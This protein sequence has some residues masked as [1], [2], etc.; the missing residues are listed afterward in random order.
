MPTCSQGCAVRLRSTLLQVSVMLIA[1]NAGRGLPAGDVAPAPEYAAI[2]LSVSEFLQ[3]EIA[4]RRIPALSIALVDGDRIVWSAGF[5]V[6]DASTGR[7]ANADTV[8]RVGSLSKLL[9]D[10]AVMQ[11]IE[12][13]KIDL[14]QD[15]RP[16]L[17][18]FA[19]RYRDDETI[20]LRRLM[21]H[22]SGLVRE[23]PVGSYFDPDDPGLAATIASLN[24]TGPVYPVGTRTKYS[25]AGIAV[26]GAVVEAVAG[27]PFEDA[28]QDALLRPLGMSSSTF[29]R[30]AAPEDRLAAGWMWSHDG[31][32]FPAPTFDLGT[33]PAG[34][35]YASVNDFGGFLAA[36]FRGGEGPQGRV[37]R[38]ETLTA[39]LTA[40]GTQPGDFGLG[41]ALS[42]FEGCRAF[43]HGGAV[44][45]F[46]TQ[47]KGLPDQKLGV[48]ATAS[49]DGANGFVSHVVDGTLSM[50]LARQRGA[51]P[52][53]LARTVDVPA[54]RARALAGRY[55]HG[56]DW[57]ELEAREGRLYLREGA[58]LSEVRG[59]YGR[60]MVDDVYAWG[61]EVEVPADDRIR[62][63][64]RTFTRV[65]TPRPAP[66]PA[67]FRGLIGEYGWDHN[68]LYIY[69]DRGQLYCL[70]EWFYFYPL[71][72]LSENEFAFP[73]AGLYHGEKLIFQRDGQGR[74]ESVEA[75][76]VVFQRREATDAAETYRITPQKLIDEL[77]PIAESATPP[78]ESG[79]F[80]PS[81]LVELTSLEPGIRLDIRYASENNFLGTVFYR[82]PR[83]FLQ[84][85]AAEAVARAH[86]RAAEHGLG[87]LVY[88]GY[89]PWSVTRMFHDAMPADLR[90]FVADPSQGSRHNRGCAVDLTLCDLATG[91]PVEMVSGYDE[92]T[93]RA[94]PNYPGGTSLGRWN[95]ALLRSL[96]E[97]QGF[98]V[99]EYEW[100]HFDFRDWRRYPIGNLPFEKLG[101]D[102]PSP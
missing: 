75:A 80:L 64:N 5:G 66:A 34:N 62:F 43:G 78:T 27:K 24:T 82:Q 90:R 46:A 13:E 2:A 97:E 33:L 6:A 52:P 53:P 95:R 91:E 101:G 54:E 40:Q 63:R 45:G 12:A 1:L 81:D 98:D 20:S 35:L 59:A 7:A 79:D 21:S 77:R 93:T 89:R 18:G 83:A 28:L 57:L 39:M 29:L 42:E 41:F 56:D 8:Y 69:E 61:P 25:N 44:Y 65:A 19:P 36:M 10:M 38:P 102:A 50:M 32:R 86:R 73:D 70:I 58:R 15:V 17:P 72:E 96:M 67:R 49:L 26:V 30:S 48:I 4:E 23:S 68:V 14:E 3:A 37:L 76:S 51:A 85:P 100:W 55:E 22:R 11:L 31:Q 87:L 99:Y 84:R 74:A 47:I 9:T 92:F 60:L 94:Y 88:D 71:K 16:L